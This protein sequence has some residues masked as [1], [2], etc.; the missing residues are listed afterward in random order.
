MKTK[1]QLIALLLL[2]I[3]FLAC[4]DQAQKR[5]AAPATPDQGAFWKKQALNDIIGP[6][7]Q[8]GMDRQN[9]TFPAFLDRQW[10]PIQ[11]RERF[12]GMLARHVFSYST[13]YM[14]TGDDRYLN[15]A[16]QLVQYIIKN[17]WD[18]Q[19]LLWFNELNGDGYPTTG[20]KELFMQLYAV[21]GLSMYYVATRD[22]RILAY[23]NNSI[24]LLNEHAWDGD[25]GG[26]YNVLNRDLSVRDDAKRATP[27]LAPLSGYL[28]Y[29][30]PATGE[31]KYL[32][33]MER[34]AETILSNMMDPDNGWLLETFDATWKVQAE[35]SA[36]VNVGHNLEI[37]WTLLRLH[38]LT[39]EESYK[40]QALELYEPL[41]EIA[42]N[43]E[44]GAWYHQF[45]RDNPEEKTGPTPWWVQ[46]YGNMLEL[47]LYRIT[48]DQ[49]HLDRFQKSAAFWNTYFIDGEYGGAVLSVTPEGQLEDG[50]KAA[51][52][53]T[54]YH[55]MEHG[56]LNYLYLNLWSKGEPVELYFKIHRSAEGDTFSPNITEDP[57]IGI[58][59][60]EINGKSWDNFDAAQGTITLPALQN[61]TVRVELAA[62]E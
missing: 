12:P 34:G 28:A 27:Q 5:N 45:N 52:T 32:Q 4:G 39:G 40:T 18:E 56:L 53:K 26:Y 43:T 38:L 33:D 58:S 7:T 36:Q 15:I 29:L 61:G 54:S 24:D 1:S 59:S 51:R 22:E 35:T 60:V 30:Y 8:D 16:T 14:L 42:F 46:A 25:N 21:T 31:D 2:T 62:R 13:A 17:G 10:Q 55:S 20:E 50:N 48:G 49:A 23:V 47:Y 6:W 3:F 11:G 41:A 44:T 9:V 57:D 19:E 37:V